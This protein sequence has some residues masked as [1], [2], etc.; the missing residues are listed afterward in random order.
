M[1]KSSLVDICSKICYYAQEHSSCEEAWGIRNSPDLWNWMQ[2]T[3]Y[4]VAC[5]IAQNTEYG[6]DGVDWDIVQRELVGPVLTLEQ[7]EQVIKEKVE[8]YE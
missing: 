5:F 4:T 8:I 3:S 6:V 7:W 2:H 1:T